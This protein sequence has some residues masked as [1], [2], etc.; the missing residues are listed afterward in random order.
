MKM[1]TIV[2]RAGIEPTSLAF[3]ASMLPFQ[4]AGSLMSPLNPCLPI[5]APP[6]L[7]AQSVQA[8][9]VSVI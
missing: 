1:G 4:H 6:C 8:T 3:W 2:L 9:T 7:R 5:Y